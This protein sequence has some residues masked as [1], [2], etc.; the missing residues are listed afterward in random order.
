M[1]YKA[2]I[3]ADASA[4]LGTIGRTG[5]EKLRHID[6]SY[7]W[8]QQESIKQKLKLNKVKGTENPADM[9][10]KGLNGDDI[11]R[12]VRMLNMEHKE[13]KSDL[14][15][16]VHQLI[17]KDRCT[18]LNSTSSKIMRRVRNIPYLGKPT[19]NLDHTAHHTVS[20][21]RGGCDSG[22]GCGGCWM[23]CC[24]NDRS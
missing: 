8:L 15:P 24:G 5:L 18:R 12:Y 3:M 6:T 2:D 13:G 4:A 19:T 16:E 14:A 1:K 11:I 10:T 20:E 17:H 9:N 23:F 7:L 21:D 22:C